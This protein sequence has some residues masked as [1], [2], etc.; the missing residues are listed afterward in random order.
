MLG[1]EWIAAN[2][3]LAYE[4]RAFLADGGGST[5]C[6]GDLLTLLELLKSAPLAAM[7]AAPLGAH[8]PGR[9]VS[10]SPR[11]WWDSEGGEAAFPHES[12]VG[13]QSSRRGVPIDLFPSL[14]PA[15]PWLIFK[16]RWQAATGLALPESAEEGPPTA[17]APPLP[18]PTP[19]ECPRPL[20]AYTPTQSPLA[21]EAVPVCVTADESA[22]PVTAEL[23]RL[24]SWCS[25]VGLQTDRMKC[26]A[27]DTA[28]FSPR[29]QLPAC[30]SY[31]TAT[32]DCSAASLL[33][34]VTIAVTI[35]PTAPRKT[36]QQESVQTYFSEDAS[37]V[38]VSLGHGGASIAL[39]LTA[40]GCAALRVGGLVVAETT[41]ALAPREW[42]TVAASLTDT[43][44]T[45]IQKPLTTMA[46]PVCA[47]KPWAGAGSTAAAA[48]ASGSTEVMFAGAM[49]DMSD[50]GDEGDDD[51]LGTYAI[52]VNPKFG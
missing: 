40:E 35:W 9:I 7:G 25:V 15:S 27:V 38:L 19:Y 21:G 30:G 50:E 26:P 23:H 31:G 5:A 13:L 48:A 11:R 4:F 47:Q 46:E 36:E 34:G 2:V 8:R 33:S 28:Q 22:G 39:L 10:V 6:S 45:V 29:K 3:H 1:P 16:L 42:C 37:Q 14:G 41:V 18:E 43:T 24:H 51:G 49:H 44:A 12:V 52:P 32:V 17:P 20:L